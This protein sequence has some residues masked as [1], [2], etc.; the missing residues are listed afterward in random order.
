MKTI[1]PKK[2]LTSTRVKNSIRCNLVHPVSQ[3]SIFL[4]YKSDYIV[5][6]INIDFKLLTP[7]YLQMLEKGDTKVYRVTWSEDAE[8]EEKAKN[9]IVMARRHTDKALAKL[10]GVNF[11]M[12]CITGVSANRYLTINIYDNASFLLKMRRVVYAKF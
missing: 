10:R 8:N 7:S 2:I 12:S 11:V 6:F 1:L 3:F 4:T 9:L 5:S